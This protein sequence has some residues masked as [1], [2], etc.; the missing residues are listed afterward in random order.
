M[1]PWRKQLVN[2]QRKNCESDTK[3]TVVGSNGFIT[4]TRFHHGQCLPMEGTKALKGNELVQTHMRHPRLVD[5]RVLER[6]D[7]PCSCLGWLAYSGVCER[8]IPVGGKI[9][10]SNRI[11]PFFSPREVGS[12]NISGIGESCWSLTDAQFLCRDAAANAPMQ[13][14]K[15]ASIGL[16]NRTI[17]FSLTH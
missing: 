4:S 11:F 14:A 1:S 2:P 9:S 17:W 6:E 13:Y 16:S 7:L 5:E 8:T 15:L 12:Y 3:Q 10:W